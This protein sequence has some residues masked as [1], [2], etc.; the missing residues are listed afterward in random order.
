MT[1]AL[2]GYLFG[3]KSIWIYV[4]ANGS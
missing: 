4:W 1:L 3:M 2:F